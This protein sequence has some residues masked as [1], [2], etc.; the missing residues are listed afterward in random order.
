MH[1]SLLQTRLRPRSQLWLL[2][3]LLSLFFRDVPSVESQGWNCRHAKAL[4]T[5]CQN[6]LWDER[7]IESLT[8]NLRG[9]AQGFLDTT[10]HFLLILMDQ[11]ALT[12]ILSGGNTV[13]KRFSNYIEYFCFFYLL[14]SWSSFRHRFFF[15]FSRNCTLR[16]INVKHGLWNHLKKWLC[17]NICWLSGHEWTLPPQW[18][19]AWANSRRQWKSGKSGML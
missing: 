19:W 3:G 1:F 9:V 6:A 14:F 8:K 5:C 15:F 16:I 10:Q 12:C 11:A 7:Q 2:T 18:T 13:G 4:T 17:K